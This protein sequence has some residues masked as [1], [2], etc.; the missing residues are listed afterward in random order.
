MTRIRAVAGGGSAVEIEPDRLVGWINRFAARNDGIA[1]LTSTLSSVTA[2][3]GNGT[4]ASIAVP[5]PP[6]APS[7]AEPVEALLAHLS[8]IGPIAL[9]LVRAAAFSVGVGENRCVVTSSTDTRYVQGRTAAGGWSQHRYARRR[10]N[11]LRDSHRAAADT[12]VRVLSAFAGT[13]G[14]LVVGGE[15]LAVRDVLADPR[16][17]FLGEL[18]RRSFPD[19]GEP[20]RAVLDDVAKR[21][22]SV[23]II[24]RAGA[25]T[26]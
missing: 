26:G 22:L 21:A 12:A 17:A 20:R 10:G 15:T 23:E 6:M 1:S 8:S 4:T 14:A 18:P 25:A 19:I 16:L 11:Q 3:A 5:F 13:L 2:T 7:G 9:I 24:V